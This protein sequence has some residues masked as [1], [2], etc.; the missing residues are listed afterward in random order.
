MDTTTEI[1]VILSEKYLEDLKIIFQ[2]GEETFGVQRA[3]LFIKSIE[4]IVNNLDSNYFMFPECRFLTTKSKIYRNIILESYLIIYRITS[5]R[6][7][8][9]RALHTSL[10]TSNRIRDIRH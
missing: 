10:C 2:Y 8:V 7:E 6:I 5:K 4:H 9:L 3:E 1:P